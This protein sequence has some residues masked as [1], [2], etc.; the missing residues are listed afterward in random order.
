MTW[1]ATTLRDVYEDAEGV[2]VHPAYEEHVISPACWCA[3]KRILDVVPIYLHHDLLDRTRVAVA[4][5]SR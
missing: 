5:E 3:P 1:T 4:G 2:H